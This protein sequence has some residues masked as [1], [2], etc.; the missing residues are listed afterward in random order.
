M[1]PSLV[2]VEPLPFVTVAIPAYNLQ[3][4]LVDAVAS[5]QGQTYDGPWRLLILD[6]GSTDDT[7][8]VARKLAKHDNR[9]EVHTQTNRGRARTRNRL[10]ELATSDL[11]AWLDA[12]DM[13][14]PTW[15]DQQVCHLLSHPDCVAVSAQ[16]YAM[17]SDGH[18]I[19]PIDRPCDSDEIERRHLSGAANAFFQSCVTVRRTAV[20][21]AGGYDERYPAAEDYSL[22]LR[23]VNVGKLC[24]LTSLH[25]YYRVHAASANWTLN[26]DQRT[27]GQAIM[28]EARRARGLQPINHP[29]EEIPEPKKDDWNRRIYWINI[30]LRSGNP[31]SAL[32]MITAAV[33][34]HPSSLVIWIAGLVATCDAILFFGN[35]TPQFKP[36]FQTH[37]KTL[38]QISCYRLARWINRNRPRRTTRPVATSD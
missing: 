1:S 31:R 34:R 11:I 37:P 7:L 32:P 26:V 27:Q 20:V 38:P 23:L 8:S 4:Y 28:N 21:D 29:V 19:G 5:V 12:D 14:S 33:R 9:I 3:R 30:A 18:P 15:I 10:V 35:R 13:A 6:D 16:G 17:T 2:S 25:L 24:N 22:W 36:G